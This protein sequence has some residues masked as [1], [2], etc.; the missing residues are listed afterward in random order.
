MTCGRDGCGAAAVWVVS[1]RRRPLDRR[2]L[3]PVAS[4]CVDHVVAI[5]NSVEG[6]AGPL[7]VERVR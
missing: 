4:V 2:R 6:A 1:R 3:V 5:L 7:Q